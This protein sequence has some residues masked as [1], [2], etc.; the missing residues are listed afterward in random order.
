MNTM[1]RQGIGRDLSL[2]H[3]PAILEA[4]RESEPQA[5]IVSEVA[6]VFHMRNF[7]AQRPQTS[8]AMGVSQAKACSGFGFAVSAGY[9]TPGTSKAHFE[10]GPDCPSLEV[11]ASGRHC[12][13]KQ[14]MS[15]IVILAARLARTITNCLAC[16]CIAKVSFNL[17]RGVKAVIVFL[18]NADMDAAGNRCI[19]IIK[20]AVVK[21]ITLNASMDASIERTRS[22]LRIREAWGYG[23]Q[24]CPGN[25]Y[26]HL[27]FSFCHMLQAG[28]PGSVTQCR[29][30]DAPRI[31]GEDV[32]FSGK[33]D[34]GLP[35]LR[36][37][38]DNT[39][40][41]VN[42]PANRNGLF[43]AWRKE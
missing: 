21:T 20:A 28:M 24:N 35:T 36:H 18:A 10:L 15:A 33:P 8:K 31:S 34:K 19:L 30:K 3:S 38:W 32:V 43:Q 25:K 7:T 23:E 6:A 5:A 13:S 16:F 22:L 9:G 41:H 12:L 4:A 40:H 11:K 26:I 39:L 1:Q 27:C 14:G 2:G 29:N 42:M 37:R 17:N